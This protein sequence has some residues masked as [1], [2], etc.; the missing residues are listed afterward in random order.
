MERPK[1]LQFPPDFKF[2]VNL[3]SPH[4]VE[5]AT[6]ATDYASI[7]SRLNTQPSQ[8]GW[9]T[10]PEL[11]ETDIALASQLG[12]RIVRFGTEWAR[13]NPEAG[14]VNH[15]ALK[16]YGEMVRMAKDQGLSLMLTLHHFTLPSFIAEQGGWSNPKVVGQFVEYTKRVMGEVGDNADYVLTTNEPS[17][18]LNNGYLKGIWPPF[19]KRSPKIIH[20]VRN[21]AKAHNTAKEIVKDVSPTTQ[22]SATEAIRG[23]DP[24][25]GIDREET[26]FR[27]FLFNTLFFRITNNDFYGINYFRSYPLKL[28]A[29]LRRQTVSQAGNEFGI[30]PEVFSAPDNFEQTLNRFLKALPGKPVIITEN[31][32]D[33]PED[34]YRPYFMLAHL[35]VVSD[36]IKRGQPIKGY[37]PW[38]LAD[39]YEWFQKLGEGQFG[40]VS[41]DFDTLKREPRESYRLYQSICQQNGK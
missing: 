3:G 1:S 26:A 34:K 5:G 25:D 33:D 9:W 18:F 13:V 21:L 2:G 38:T 19:H 30:D 31:G 8:K 12:I 16:R 27:E 22:V 37:M 28:G 24:K 32:L 39:N 15:V 41:A 20:A 14:S 40:L 4:Q 7:E 29:K 23:F 6:P 10:N 36:A 35:K 17:V 11:F